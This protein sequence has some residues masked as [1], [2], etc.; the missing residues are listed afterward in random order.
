MP[1][2]ILLVSESH[3]LVAKIYKVKI[4]PIAAKYKIIKN[5]MSLM[6]QKYD[7][8]FKNVSSEIW[9]K[10]IE[11][12]RPKIMQYLYIILYI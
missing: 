10:V 8:L 2:N 6:K 12:M 5:M 11:T 9:V 1:R 3:I 4:R 7:I